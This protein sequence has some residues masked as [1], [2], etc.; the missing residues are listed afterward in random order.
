MKKNLAN[1]LITFILIIFL[2]I[3]Y[4]STIGIETSSFNQQIKDKINENNKN[5]KIDLKKIKLKLDPI[6]FKLNAK[7]VGATIYYSNRPIKL[8]YIATEVSFASIVKNK[9]VSSNLEISSNSLEIRDLIKF[10]RA[11]YEGP[12]LIILEKIVKKGYVTL[13]IKINY[14]E[15]G[16]INNDYEVK[17]ILKNANI[18]HLNNNNFEKI[19]FIFN[20]RKEEFEFKEINFVINKINFF[21]DTVNVKQK[22][23]TFYIEGIVK[24]KESIL[25]DTF[26]NIL[27]V[28]YK[29]FSFNNT[30]F[31]SINNFNFEITKQFKL[32]NIFLKSDISLNK[33]Q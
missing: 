29:N 26:L 13:N 15:D 4:L 31:N 30:I 32:K 6:R 20:F 21:A 9:F 12:E 33:A 10:I 22:K 27:N 14:D 5:F 28:N 19:N 16:K 25:S 3:I 7:T 18:Q 2:P 11:A 1:Y 24:N 8:E 17:G 23:D